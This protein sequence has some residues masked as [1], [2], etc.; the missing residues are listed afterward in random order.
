MRWISSFVVVA[1][2]AAIHS[3]AAQES[4]NFLGL[5]LKGSLGEGRHS[6]YVPPV[7]NPRL[8]SLL[9]SEAKSTNVRR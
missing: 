9:N 1:A 2:I 8:V 4:D 3:A 6:R 7:S 5:D